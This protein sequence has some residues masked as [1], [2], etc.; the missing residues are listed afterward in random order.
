MVWLIFDYCFWHSSVSNNLRRWFSWWCILYSFCVYTVHP[1]W[2][3]SC[4][5]VFAEIIFDCCNSSYYTSCFLGQNCIS[6]YSVSTWK[7]II[8][9]SCTCVKVTWKFMLKY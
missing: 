4:L 3:V 6:D 8:K 1:S 9:W 7:T 5:F 2:I